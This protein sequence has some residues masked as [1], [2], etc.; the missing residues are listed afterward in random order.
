MVP[1]NSVIYFCYYNNKKITQEGHLIFIFPNVYLLLPQAS[2]SLAG[3][4]DKNPLL[5]ITWS[6]FNLSNF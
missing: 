4:L 5:P 1:F 6:A 2:P 3:K